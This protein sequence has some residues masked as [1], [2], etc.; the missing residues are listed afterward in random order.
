L[1]S[2]YRLGKE[3]TF[4]GDR[5]KVPRVTAVQRWSGRYVPVLTIVPDSAERESSAASL[6]A[7]VGVVDRRS[8]P[9]G[10][11]ITS[12]GPGDLFTVRNLGNMVPAQ[13][14][15]VSI[16]AA[17]EY[18]IEHLNISSVVV[19]GHPGCG[20]M[21]GLLAGPAQYRRSCGAVVIPWRVK[22]RFRLRQHDRHGPVLAALAAVNRHRIGRLHADNTLGWI[23]SGAPPAR[24]PPPPTSSP[25]TTTQCRR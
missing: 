23:S 10:N 14:H 12:A 25:A 4:P 21:R 3:R 18:A 8:C 13:G 5:L 1:K 17:L 2:V 20:A 7:G 11:T 16:E 9:G 6:V 24:S 22:R 15:D 19:C